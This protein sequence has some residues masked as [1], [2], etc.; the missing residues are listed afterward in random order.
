MKAGKKG[1]ITQ[2]W[3]AGPQEG[4]YVPMED[5]QVMPS[6]AEEGQP[7]WLADWP[8]AS[9]RSRLP[10]RIDGSSRHRADDPAER[11]TTAA[12]AARAHRAL[13]RLHDPG[14]GLEPTSGTSKL[15]LL[16][17]LVKDASRLDASP[18]QQAGPTD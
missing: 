15:K 2:A 7:P 9:H 16:A 18:A 10:R 1:K 3:R 12:Q 4:E 11:A 6:T 17:P 14:I 13:E 8:T 5:R